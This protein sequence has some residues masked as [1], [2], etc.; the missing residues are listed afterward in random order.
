MNLWSR[1]YRAPKDLKLIS[2]VAVASFALVACGS[3]AGAPG[4][5]GA[6][7]KSAA[8][9][10]VDAATAG[11]I[12]G[13]VTL[14]GTPPNMRAIDM[15]AEPSC[16]KSYSSPIISPMV[17]AD[18]HG[19]LANAVVY[20]KSGVEDYAFRAP[21]EPAKLS[22]KGCMYE[23]HVVAVMAGQNLDVANED[24]ATHNV[25]LMSKNNQPSNRS[26]QPGS[27]PIVESL[28]APELAIPVKCNV[29]PWMKGYVFVFDHPYFAVTK[30]DG[31]FE[32]NGV[33]SGTYTVVAWQ[34][35]YGTTEQTVTVAPK[36][37]AT[38]DFAFK[39]Q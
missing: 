12:S 1:R 4:E 16:A 33:P 24:Q 7:K 19:D 21:A 18:S 14:T 6:A 31:S 35:M 39:A 25:F 28:T 8:T 5:A 37:A 38:A 30:A 17:V 34:E 9:K 2:V 22:Q 36:Q 13:R 23:P 32:L 29:H 3:G 27:A 10:T 20:I 15:S 11:S 26:A